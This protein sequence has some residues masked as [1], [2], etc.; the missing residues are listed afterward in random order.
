MVCSYFNT[1]FKNSFFNTER[2]NRVTLIKPVFIY[3]NEN[4]KIETKKSE[5]TDVSKNYSFP[6]FIADPIMYCNSDD[7]ELFAVI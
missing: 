4:R 1:K 2:I 7:F 5:K 3:T 6:T